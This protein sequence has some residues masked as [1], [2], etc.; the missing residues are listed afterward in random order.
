MQTKAK[1]TPVIIKM[2]WPNLDKYIIHIPTA[3]THPVLDF[4]LV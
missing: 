2:F 4:K 1:S 3:G